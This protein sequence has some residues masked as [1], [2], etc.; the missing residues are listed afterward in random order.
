MS[1]WMVFDKNNKPLGVYG[2]SAH[3][4]TKLAIKEYG[5]ENGPYIVERVVIKGTDE[6]GKE[7]YSSSTVTITDTSP[8]PRIDTSTQPIFSD[9]NPKNQEAV[10]G[11]VLDIHRLAR[12][13]DMSFVDMVHTVKQIVIGFGLKLDQA[14]MDGMHSGKTVD[15]SELKILTNLQEDLKQQIEYFQTSLEKDKD[16]KRD[17]RKRQRMADRQRFKGKKKLERF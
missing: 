13:M 1:L 12:K 9:P 14:Y 10:L 8:A 17:R 7:F 2:G 4:A 15:V 11:L 3:E 6:Q 16:T 5:L